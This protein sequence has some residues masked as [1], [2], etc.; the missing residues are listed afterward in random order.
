MTTEEQIEENGYA[1]RVKHMKISVETESGSRCNLTICKHLTKEK[2]FVDD[3]ENIEG[4]EYLDKLKETQFMDFM[5]L[6][7]AIAD[8]FKGEFE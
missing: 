3:V 6:C 5:A 7:N 4:F 1:V 8:F 2:L